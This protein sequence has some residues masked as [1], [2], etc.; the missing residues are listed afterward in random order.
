M[1]IRLK[2]CSYEG[3][4]YINYIYLLIKVRISFLNYNKSFF[5]LTSISILLKIIVAL[6]HF[7]FSNNWLCDNFLYSFLY[8]IRHKFFKENKSYCNW[9]I[10]KVA[11]WNVL[12]LLN[13]LTSHLNFNWVY[14][15][16]IGFSSL[17]KV[18]SIMMTSRSHRWSF[19]WFGLFLVIVLTVAITC[20]LS[21]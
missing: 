2:T 4:R 14:K 15:K 9:P 10:T 13:F 11:D 8:D 5:K 16:L 12:K 6:L 18:Y 7:N 1:V 3:K 19:P 20:F 17:W 21:K